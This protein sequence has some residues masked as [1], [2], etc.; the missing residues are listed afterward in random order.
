MQALFGIGSTSSKALGTRLELGVGVLD[1]AHS[2]GAGNILTITLKQNSVKKQLQYSFGLR[3]I[4]PTF[5]LR[6]PSFLLF[7]LFFVV[8]FRFFVY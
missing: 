7:D 1:F 4:A 3:R 2:C 5:T 6:L 8:L